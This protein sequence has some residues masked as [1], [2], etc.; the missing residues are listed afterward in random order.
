MFTKKAINWKLII[1][2]GEAVEN[3]YIT[4]IVEEVSSEKPTVLEGFP[5]IGLVG[6]IVAS[7][8][9]SELKMKQIGTIESRLFPPISVLF[10]GIAYAPV[11]I[12]EKPQAN[13]IV[14]VSDIL[15]HPMVAFDVG[16]A[17]VK[18]TINIGAKMNIPIAGISTVR[19]QRVVFGSATSQEHLD[20]IKDKVETLTAG[21]ISGIAGSIMNECNIAKMPAICLLGETQGPTP[22]PRASARVIEVLNSILNL[23]VNT[24]KL[25][26]EAEHIETEL[27]KL[28]EQ[29]QGVEQ[30]EPRGPRRDLM[31][32]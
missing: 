14:I 30:A 29:V 18:W 20:L 1:M 12:Y 25:V 23:N 32:G 9:V 31:Y 8:L 13:F 11:R 6:N 15:I 17:I 28:A 21:S 2:K 5:G 3:E 4:M 22:D 19:E 7:H 16:K 26:E 24:Q 27:H 10:N